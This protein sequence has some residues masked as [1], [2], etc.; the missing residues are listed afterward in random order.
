MVPGYSTWPFTLPG[1]SQCRR[2]LRSPTSL[3][4]SFACVGQRLHLSFMKQ[5]SATLVATCWKLCGVGWKKACSPWSLGFSYC[6]SLSLP[7][8]PAT[9]KRELQSFNTASFSCVGGSPQ[10]PILLRYNTILFHASP[11]CLH[12]AS[13]I[14]AGSL[15][16]PTPAFPLMPLDFALCFQGQSLTEGLR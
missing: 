2:C 16:A 14:C 3:S 5:S 6:P 10:V 12:E 13:P 9:H 4:L 1:I 15:F 8:P 11:P 7:V